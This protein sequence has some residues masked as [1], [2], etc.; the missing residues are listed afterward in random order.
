M[1]V[2]PWFR[3]EETAHTESLPRLREKKPKKQTLYEESQ[4]K[5]PYNFKT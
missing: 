3:I 4:G 5:K 1:A 2:M